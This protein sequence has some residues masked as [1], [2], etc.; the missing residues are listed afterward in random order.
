[1]RLIQRDL[2]MIKLPTNSISL[3][4]Y[5]Y[6]FLPAA[7]L[8]FCWRR[9]LFRH[10]HLNSHSE[11]HSV[12][13]STPLNCSTHC[14]LLYSQAPTLKVPIATAEARAAFRGIITLDTPERA[15]ELANDIV[16]FTQ[17]AGTIVT[18]CTQ[19]FSPFACVYIVLSALWTARR[20]AS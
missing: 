16:S 20:K 8:L 7:P 18:C 14:S 13:E 11:L 17:Q 19:M 2:A 10:K 9:C 1:M 12:V 15:Q 3:N 5:I 6:I 4:Y